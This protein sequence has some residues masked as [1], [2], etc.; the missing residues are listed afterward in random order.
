MK[1][2]LLTLALLGILNIAIAQSDPIE[3]IVNVIASPVFA[4]MIFAVIVPGYIGYKTAEK[5]GS[6]PGG[7]VF[8]IGFFAILLSYTVYYSEFQY[9][10]II[11]IIIT[12][13]LVAVVILKMIGGGG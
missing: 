11:S 13:I 8:F 3:A 1:K 2:L 7:V 4:L 6:I 10:L 12:S 5:W 9:F